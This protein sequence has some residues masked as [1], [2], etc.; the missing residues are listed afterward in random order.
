MT[1]E[2]LGKPRK[3]RKAKPCPGDNARR[4]LKK[5]DFWVG[6]A[7]LVTPLLLV[8]LGGKDMIFNV[9]LIYPVISVI[10]FIVRHRYLKNLPSEEL[11]HIVPWSHIYTGRGISMV[12]LILTFFSLAMTLFNEACKLWPWL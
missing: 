6:C 8:L 5:M 1:T 12:I 3:P 10:F 2:K 9:I 7:Y 4:V 11:R